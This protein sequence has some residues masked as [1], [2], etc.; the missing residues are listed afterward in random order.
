LRNKELASNLLTIGIIAGL[1]FLVY[2]LHGKYS[3]GPIDEIA[4][5]KALV[6][7]MIKKYEGL[8]LT[9][10]P[11]GG[12]TAICY[13]NEFNIK[14]VKATPEECER[15]LDAGINESSDA[16][17][18][19]VDVPLSPGQRAA[20]IDFVYNLGRGSLAT[21]ILLEKLNSGD[22]D[23]AGEELLMWIYITNSDGEKEVSVKLQFRCDEREVLWERIS[24]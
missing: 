8:S 15:L 17:S 23:G 9:P 4:E 18:T 11:D 14:N 1:I 24:S 20:L 22:Y 2:Y 12:R 13:G 10:Y 19:L 6:R 5:A 21:S 3:F 16:V 7:P